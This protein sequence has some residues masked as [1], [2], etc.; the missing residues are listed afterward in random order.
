LEAPPLTQHDLYIEN[1]LCSSTYHGYSCLGRVWNYGIS[2]VQDV[3]LRVRMRDQ[4]E[5][6]TRYYSLEQRMI[7]PGT[8]APF[9]IVFAD[10]QLDAIEGVAALSYAERTPVPLTIVD[11]RGM[12]NANGRYVITTSIRN[13]SGYPLGQIR[14][15]AT[16][17]DEWDRV[18]GYRIQERNQVLQVGENVVFRIEM[19]AQ[20]GEINHHYLHAEGQPSY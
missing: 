10:G 9:R 15:V 8:F 3:T 4:D 6:L 5:I 11:E 18:V 2:T 19:N 17:V 13:D 14:T 20:V 7:L 1:P 12:Y 16:V